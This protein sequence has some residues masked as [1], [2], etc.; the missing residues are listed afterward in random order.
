MTYPEWSSDFDWALIRRKS[1]DFNVP[2]AIIAATIQVESAGNTYAMRFEPG[3]RWTWQIGE[4]A[5]KIGMTYATMETAQKT[6]WGLMQIMYGVALEH[7][8]HGWPS[9]LAIPETGVHFGCMHLKQKYQ[10]YGPDP[11]HTYA[12][13]NAGSIRMTSGGFFENQKSVDRFMKF[14]RELEN[15]D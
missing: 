9:E 12:A 2:A 4:W 10:K 6:S 11:A 13:Y 5:N 3:Y 15:I 1:G 7:R 8:F 14:F